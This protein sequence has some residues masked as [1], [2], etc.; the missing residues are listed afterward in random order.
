MAAKGSR[1]ELMVAKWGNSLAVRLPAGSAKRIGVGEGD[2][3]VAEIS[4]DGRLI[5]APEGRPIGKAESRRLRR[6]LSR[7]KETAPV[8]AHMRRDARY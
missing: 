4:S 3:L 7:Q 5:L 6:F 8:I 2:T 1:I